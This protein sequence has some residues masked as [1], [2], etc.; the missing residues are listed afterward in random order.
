MYEIFLTVARIVQRNSFHFELAQTIRGL[1]LTF[2]IYLVHLKLHDFAC[3]AFKILV[4]KP[5]WLFIV[6]RSLTNI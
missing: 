4:V 3:S 6:S 2:L 1:P 5:Q